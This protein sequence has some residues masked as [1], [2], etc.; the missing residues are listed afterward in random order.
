[1]DFMKKLILGLN[2]TEYVL[3]IIAT[4]FVII[5]QFTGLPIFVTLSLVIYT[6]A[7]LIVFTIAVIQCKEYFD[8]SRGV[9]VVK[10]KDGVDN[11]D[12]DVIN[13]KN[14]KTWAIIKA[15]ASGVFAIFTFVVLILF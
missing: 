2:I 15:I 1:M 5:F 8:A 10:T 3:F 11:K 14:E 12:F 4:V 13:I 7:F 6:V 9:K